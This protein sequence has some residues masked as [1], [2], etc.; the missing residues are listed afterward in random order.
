MQSIWVLDPIKLYHSLGRFCRQQIDDFFSYVS[1]VTT[2]MECQSLFSAK[3]LEKYFKMS[4][5]IFTHMLSINDIE[6]F[7]WKTKI[8]SLQSI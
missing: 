1:K 7:P 8:T 2:G 6:K 5:E 4:A 3:K